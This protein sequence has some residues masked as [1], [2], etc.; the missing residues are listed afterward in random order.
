MRIKLRKKGVESI[1]CFE[2]INLFPDAKS[3]LNTFISAI[4]T[5]VRGFSKV[6]ESMPIC[7]HDRFVGNE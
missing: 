4:S 5:I 7:G 2:Q 6:G 1:F 3:D